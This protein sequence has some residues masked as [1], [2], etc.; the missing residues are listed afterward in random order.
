MLVPQQAVTRDPMG[1]ANVFVVN[2]QGKAELR[3]LQVSQ[4]AV[5]GNWLVLGGLA[6]GERV[7]TEGLQKVKA[8]AAV[9]AVPAG[10]LP[11]AGPPPGG[12]NQGSGRP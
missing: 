8:G 11:R 6:P 2:A 4:T 10:S 9:R 12:P 1:A 5:G 7:I 3:P